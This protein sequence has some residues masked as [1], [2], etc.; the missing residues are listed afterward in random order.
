MV[1]FKADD[2]VRQKMEELPAYTP[3]AISDILPIYRPLDSD[4]HIRIYNLRQ[5]SPHTQTLSLCGDAPAGSVT[6][7]IKSNETGG[8]MN[9]KPHIIITTRGDV[10]LIAEGRYDIHGTG[11]TLSYPQVGIQR[12][13]L[14]DSLAQVLKTRIHGS[15]LWWQPHPGNKEVL[16][17]TNEMDEIIARFTCTTK[18][19]QRTGSWPESRG[20][21]SD[22][23]KNLDVDMGNLQVVGTS[24]AEDTEYE[25]ILCSAI[26]VIERA[27]RRTVNIM[28]SG[29]AL[30]GPASWG[31]SM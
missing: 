22:F 1:F 31:Y 27:R 29:P 6:Y 20:S 12:L 11:T 13:E 30:R 9:R 4:S 28:K 10:R 19:S 21:K 5:T 3:Q 18:V 16:E 24:T 15:D 7:D 8:F 26:M 17:L 14:Q 2:T 25:Q 23:K